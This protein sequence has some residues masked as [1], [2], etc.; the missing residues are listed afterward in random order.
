MTG[1]VQTFKEPIKE[2]KTVGY[3]WRIVYTTKKFIPSEQA[4]YKGDTEEVTNELGGNCDTLGQMYNEWNGARRSLG[5]IG[6][7][8]KD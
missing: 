7:E 1:E 2:I 5:L 6:I 8:Q 3:R 4:K